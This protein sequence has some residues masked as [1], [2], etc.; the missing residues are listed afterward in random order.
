M[1]QIIFIFLIIIISI[2]CSNNHTREV[3]KYTIEQFL[4]NI[5]T[6]GGYF[7]PDE[8]KLLVTSNKTGIPNVFSILIEN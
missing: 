7:S 5:L 4:K 6:G 8:S 3:K 2:S 1:K